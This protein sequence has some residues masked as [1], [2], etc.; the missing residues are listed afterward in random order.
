MTI[1]GEFNTDVSDMFAVHQGILKALDAASELVNKALA[2]PERVAAVTSFYDNV[3]EFLHVHHQGEDELIYPRLEELCISDDDM[4]IRIDD[5][6][7]T[8]YAPMDA[9]WEC[10]EL[11]RSD[12][13]EH[14]ASALISALGTVD[15]TLRPHLV[16]EEQNVLPL[17]TRWIS[18]EEWAQLPGHAMMTFRKDKPWLALGL[19]REQLDDAQRSAM[20]ETMPPPVREL[21]TN[22]WEPAFKSFISE[23]RH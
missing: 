11:F 15:V 3:L 5:Q 13:T 16:E 17:A 14:S 9:A 6:H 1:P 19:V 2:D 12:P 7:K 21:W 8:L 4:L 23:V 22:E 18:P 20:L 10:V